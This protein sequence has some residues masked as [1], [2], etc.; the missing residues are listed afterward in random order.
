MTNHENNLFDQSTTTLEPE[1]GWTVFDPFTSLN[2]VTSFVSG[3]PDGERIRIRYFLRQSDQALVGKVWFG[4]GAEGPPKHAHGGSIAAVLD[5][6]M[7]GAAWLAGYPSVASKLVVEYRRM[8]P[9]GS[10]ATVET[11]IAAVEGRK[12][13][14]RARLLDAK[15]QVYAEAEGLFVTIALERFGKLGEQA[16]QA[17]Q[18]M[19]N[20]VAVAHPPAI[21]PAPSDCLKATDIIDADHPALRDCLARL[22]VLPLPLPERAAALFRFVR[23][24]VQYEFS[25]KMRRDEYVASHVLTEAKG[26]CVQKAVLL[27]ALGRAA[28]IPTALVLTDLRD[29][30]LSPR[31]REMMG[32]DIMHHHGLNAFYLDGRWLK[33]DASLSPDIMQRKGYRMVE[34][35]GQQDALLAPTTLAG[36]PH[37][38][39]LVFHGLYDDLPYEQIMAAFRAAYPLMETP[40]KAQSLKDIFPQY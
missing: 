17:M 9:L 40:D 12:V 21:M 32:T 5:E 29:C 28:G 37:A 25:A 19:R 2:A 13:T 22:D 34:F 3:E 38:E 14:T 18:S 6:T 16:T 26:Y 20:H 35:N 27:C 11:S 36:Q 4:P 39:Y 7:G 15:S 1:P 33:A 31:I 24:Q 10:I 30:T 23:D 8:L